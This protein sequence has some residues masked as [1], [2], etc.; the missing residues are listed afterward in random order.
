MQ[1]MLPCC[2]AWAGSFLTRVRLILG[3]EGADM[4]LSVERPA[5][6]D[7]ALEPRA[8]PAPSP[9]DGDLDL[10]QLCQACAGAE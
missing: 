4:R 8:R 10:A 6:R 5:V 1:G 7:G 2:W 9:T 3:Q